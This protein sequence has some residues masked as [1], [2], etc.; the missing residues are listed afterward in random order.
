MEDKNY[1]EKDLS[2]LIKCLKVI[3]EPK[4]I[5]LLD[6]IISGVQCNCELGSSLQMA[7]NLTSHHLSILKDSGLINSERDPVDGRWI[8]YSINLEAMQDMK[9]ALNSFF[10]EKRIHPRRLS[11]GPQTEEK[12]ILDVLN[13]K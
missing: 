11:C 3:G 7:A 6:K 13:F 4:R 10:D 12:N 8:Y 2:E 1:S 9:S 5:M